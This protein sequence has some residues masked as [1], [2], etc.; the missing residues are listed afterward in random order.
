MCF[1]GFLSGASMVSLMFF[2]GFG[3]HWVLFWYVPFL[4]LGLWGAQPS[5][6]AGLLI[7]CFFIF[8]VCLFFLFC[9]F[10]C[11][12][13]F[14]ILLMFMGLCLLTFV[15]FVPL[16]RKLH[17]HQSEMKMLAVVWMHSYRLSTLYDVY[18]LCPNDFPSQHPQPLMHIS[19]AVDDGQQICLTGRMKNPSFRTDQCCSEEKPFTV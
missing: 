8:P 16:E 14:F 17:C 18:E 13:L 6:V 12:L 5:T 2:L 10:F 11:F 3:G 7:I 1:R 19:G 9:V 15:L 4:G